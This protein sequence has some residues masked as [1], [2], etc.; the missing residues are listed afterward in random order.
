MVELDSDQHKILSDILSCKD[1]KTRN[2]HLILGKAGCGKSFFISALSSITRVAVTATTAR[3]AYLINGTTID[4]ALSFNRTTN[5]FRDFNGIPTLMS[6]LPD[7]ILLDEASMLGAASFEPIFNLI[8]DYGKRLILVG[9]FAQ[10]SPVKDLWINRSPL[11]K[12]V[13][14]RLTKN[15]RQSQADFIQMLDEI[16]QGKVSSETDE[17]FTQKSFSAPQ[18]DAH[19]IIYASNA[20]AKAY[21][22]KKLSVI[23]AEEYTT[24]ASI[25]SGDGSYLEL[26]QSEKEK[27]V[28]DAGLSNND[29]FKVG[30]K[31]IL[32]KNNYDK[33]YINSD[34]GEIISIE[35]LDNPGEDIF[36]F[37]TGK[38]TVDRF[39]VKLERNNNII[40]VCKTNIS[41]LKSDGSVQYELF[42]FPIKLGWAVTIH[43]SQGGTFD[44]VHFDISSI[45]GYKYA[46]KQAAISDGKS[47]EE[48]EIHAMKALHGLL[49]VGLSRA[50]SLEGLTVHGWNKKYVYSDPDIQDLL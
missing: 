36:G 35:S 19:V 3:A 9:D 27:I 39:I 2:L 14:H 8:R 31:V 11:F 46:A 10:A 22:E 38:K 23:N 42:G 7:D 17:F 4:S 21:N 5:S 48:A 15:H 20:K 41:I 34:V 16:R 40:E 30:A 50:T 32:T 13:V 12:P 47:P 29:T 6:N 43:K 37:S 44:K 26:S 28:S 24:K 33:G 49:Y 25:S 1:R 45:N 18:D